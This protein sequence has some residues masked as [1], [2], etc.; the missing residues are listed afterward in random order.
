M[1]ETHD[2]LFIDTNVLVYAKLENSDVNKH[3][4]ANAFLSGLSG[5]VYLSTQVLNEF[6]TVLARNKI[7]DNVIQD[8][9]TAIL[10]EVELNTIQLET[11][12]LAWEIR[13]KYQYNYYDCLIIATALESDC[14]VLY[15]EDMQ[16]N[17]IIN[18]KLKITNPFYDE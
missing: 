3:Q 15:S 7:A 2:R 16:H 18:D 9:I 10:E 17:Q 4:K 1:K 5:Q 14:V 8:A 11:I 13:A 6:F 12:H